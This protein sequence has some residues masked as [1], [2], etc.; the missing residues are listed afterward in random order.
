MRDSFANATAEG[1]AVIILHCDISDVGIPDNFNG[2]AL[3]LME[4]DERHE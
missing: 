2:N 3:K 4:V 1:G